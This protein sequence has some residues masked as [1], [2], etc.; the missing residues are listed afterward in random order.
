[1]EDKGEK[2]FLKG[3]IFLS[4]LAE[5]VVAKQNTGESEL[6]DAAW[7][8]LQRMGFNSFDDSSVL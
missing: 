8:P 4:K 7:A 2:V 6:D 1:L 3:S 5:I